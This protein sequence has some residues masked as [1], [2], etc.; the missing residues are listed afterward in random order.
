VDAREC[1]C[2]DQLIFDKHTVRRRRYSAASPLRRFAA[3][4]LR[5]FAASPLR[6]FAASPLQ[7]FRRPAQVP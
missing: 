1:N 6:R 4:P 2:V 7:R 5:R 3:S